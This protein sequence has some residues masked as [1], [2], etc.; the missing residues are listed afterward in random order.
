[1]NNLFSTFFYELPRLVPK[2]PPHKP[3]I[4]TFNRRKLVEYQPDILI[5]NF[6]DLIKEVEN[7]FLMTQSDNLPLVKEDN[8]LICVVN[9]PRHGKSLFLD[10]L[11]IHRND[12]RVVEITYNNNTRVY[13]EEI[14]SYKIA[15]FYFWL[16]FIQSVT[17]T[18]Y[19][20]HQ[21]Q[22][23]VGRFDPDEHYNLR[24]AKQIILNKFNM[25]PFSYQA[26][27]N[28]TTTEGWNDNKAG[29]TDYPLVIAVD[30]FTHI[31][32][33]TYKKWSYNNRIDF[34]NSF[35][36]N[37]CT[38]PFVKFVFTG[39]NHNMNHYLEPSSAEIYYI[40]LTLCDFTSAKPLLRFI[41]NEYIRMN[42]RVPMVLYEVVKSTPG[43]IGLWAESVEKWMKGRG[44]GRERGRGRGRTHR[45]TNNRRFFR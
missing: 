20:L 29:W 34:L 30:E 5:G 4:I 43:L 45:W 2:L 35:K 23:I 24:W 42:R 7:H 22:H 21:L 39:F 27:N 37:L 26:N 40:T 18:N 25:N 28:G 1:M 15:I 38:K 14:E 31:L 12:I 36:N 11:F 16:R 41:I 19:N 6:N 33:S 44:T 32:D 10:R 8:R 17:N 13:E 3:V 9:P